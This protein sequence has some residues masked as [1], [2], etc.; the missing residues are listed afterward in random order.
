MPIYSNSIVRS[1]LKLKPIRLPTRIPLSPNA[2]HSRFSHTLPSN[3]PS[4]AFRPL[5]PFL[6]PSFYF[7]F[8]TSTF[9]QQVRRP[10]KFQSVTS[11]RLLL[12]SF[13][14]TTWRKSAPSFHYS[15]LHLILSHPPLSPSLISRLPQISL[16]TLNTTSTS[17]STRVDSSFGRAFPMGSLGF[18][19]SCTLTL[20]LISLVSLTLS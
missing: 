5:P 14:F 17:R 20:S 10:L 15:Q 19:E 11:F 7:L 2:S 4:P 16:G 1:G 8:F 3:H 12:P 13:L 18:V 9:K 6:S